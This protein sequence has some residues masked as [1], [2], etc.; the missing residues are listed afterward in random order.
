MQD[1]V[2]DAPGKS[3]LRT[4]L[5]EKTFR[6]KSNKQRRR[7]LEEN[8]CLHVFCVLSSLVFVRRLITH[9]GS[10]ARCVDKLPFVLQSMMTADDWS[11]HC[12]G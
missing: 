12:F 11:E 8:S 5:F 4:Q 2:E 10:R 1:S 6:K 3:K 7:S 9:F